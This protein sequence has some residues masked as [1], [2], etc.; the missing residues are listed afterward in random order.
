[1][2][3]ELGK[4]QTDSEPQGCLEFVNV[5]YEVVMSLTLH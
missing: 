3:A 1:M 2:V 4:T 5:E